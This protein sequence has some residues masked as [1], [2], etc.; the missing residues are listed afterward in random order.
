MNLFGF[1]ISRT[2]QPPVKRSIDP[3]LEAWL[4][5][6]NLDTGGPVLTCTDPTCNKVERVDV[7][8]LQR[9]AESLRLTCRKCN[10]TLVVSIKGALGNFLKCRDCGENTSWQFVAGYGRTV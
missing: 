5:G 1:Q 8:T 6:E 7:Q 9:L 10:S 3:H 4:K 2:P